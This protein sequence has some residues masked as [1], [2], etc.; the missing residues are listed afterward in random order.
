MAPHPG[1]GSLGHP[2]A[3]VIVCDSVHSLIGQW[4]PLEN[5]EFYGHDNSG[6]LGHNIFHNHVM[7]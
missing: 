4:T 2:T 7:K 3:R 1:F 6:I 5:S